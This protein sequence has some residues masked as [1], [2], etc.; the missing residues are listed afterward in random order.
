MNVFN[1]GFQ[2]KVLHI[3]IVFAS[4]STDVLYG[5]TVQL[6][7]YYVDV[8]IIKPA[9]IINRF[10]LTNGLDNYIIYSARWRM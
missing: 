1:L 3:L 7:V 10:L 6:N 8:Y 2:R 5:R 4:R 9:M